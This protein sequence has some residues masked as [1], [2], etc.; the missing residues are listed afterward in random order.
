MLKDGTGYLVL[1]NFPTQVQIQLL[2]KGKAANIEFK[3]L[4]YFWYLIYNKQ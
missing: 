1:K 2:L 3:Q 4:Q